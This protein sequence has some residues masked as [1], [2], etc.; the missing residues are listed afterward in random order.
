MSQNMIDC[1]VC[2]NEVP[3]GAPR[4]KHCFSDLSEHWEG[5]NLP[6][7][8]GLVVAL[9]VLTLIL[10]T[11]VGWAWQKV[12][13]RSQLGLVTMDPREQRVVLVYTHSDKP[14]TTRQVAYRDIASIEM[15]GVQQ[16]MG[17][18]VWSVFAVTTVGERVLLN[19]SKAA[20]LDGYANSVAAATN[21]QLTL[22]NQ[23]KMPVGPGG[24]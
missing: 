6:R 3:L 24:A 10:G 12:H 23:T 14:P 4:C 18:N 20:P 21:K 1:P 7:I 9:V 5:T 22:I 19:R 11:T 17:G 2:K 13:V 16:P 15:E 8:G